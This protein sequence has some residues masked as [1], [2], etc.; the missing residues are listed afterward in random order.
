MVDGEHQQ[1]ASGAAGPDVGG[2]QERQGIAAAGKRDRDG[3][4]AA[5]TQAPVED[6]ADPGFQVGR[7]L[8]RLR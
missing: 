8:R 3:V 1:A 5:G 6:G 7:R 4:V 2:Q